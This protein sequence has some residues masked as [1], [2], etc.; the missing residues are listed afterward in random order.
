MEEKQEWQ[1]GSSMS[2]GGKSLDEDKRIWL[3]VFHVESENALT[4]LK[5]RSTVV[6]A[7]GVLRIWIY[8][9]GLCSVILENEMRWEEEAW[10]ICILS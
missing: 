7:V 1:I 9:E 3:D 4:F 8:S 6:S 2:S 10:W 5:S